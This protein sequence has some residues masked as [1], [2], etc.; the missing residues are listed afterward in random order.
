M[1]NLNKYDKKISESENLW[2]IVSGDIDGNF[3]IA[4]FSKG[5]NNVCVNQNTIILEY[6]G[7]SQVDFV[8]NFE[9]EDIGFY[10]NGLVYVKAK[11]DKTGTAINQGGTISTVAA[12]TLER[13]FD[14]PLDLAASGLTLKMT[15]VKE[16]GCTL[17]R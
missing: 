17:E 6:A 3:S 14:E 13:G 16:L 2:G 9:L 8:A 1:N 11:L 10:A 5:D 15:V 7:G 12:Y 4:I